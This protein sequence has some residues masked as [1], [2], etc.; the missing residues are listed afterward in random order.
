MNSELRA[1]GPYPIGFNSNLFPIRIDTHALRCMAGYPHLF[2]DL[3]LSDEGKVEGIND[4]LKIMGKG[5]LKLKVEDNN[6]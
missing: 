1:P 3:Q 6:G 5:T 4:W 2:E